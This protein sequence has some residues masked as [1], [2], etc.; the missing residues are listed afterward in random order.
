MRKYHAEW[1]KRSTKENFFYWLDQGEGKDVELGKCS[2]DRLE[3]MQV[4]YLGKEERRAY[5]VVVDKQG[6]L[7]WRKDGVRVD[8]SDAWRDSVQGIVPVDD[9]APEWAHRPAHQRGSSESSG[10]DSMDEERS[11]APT[12]NILP[13]SKMVDT[14]PMSPVNETPASPSSVFSKARHTSF[15]DMFR[16]PTR[17]D[18][19]GD[20]GEKKDVKQDAKKKKKTKNNSK[21]IFV[22]DTKNK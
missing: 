18:G 22:S 15:H 17:T 1:Q 20:G 6:K 10:I 14:P 9:P 12:K 8:T 21:F 3:N 5:E 19:V 4:R 2:R 7:C 11:I 13:D 16:L